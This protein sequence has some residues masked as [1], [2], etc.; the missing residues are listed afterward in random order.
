MP[1]SMMCLMWIA[2]DDEN[3]TRRISFGDNRDRAEEF[4][5]AL[6]GWSS[7]SDSDPDWLPLTGVPAASSSP[8]DVS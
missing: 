1:V 7:R 2:Q 4:T 8:T 5:D 3:P 6:D